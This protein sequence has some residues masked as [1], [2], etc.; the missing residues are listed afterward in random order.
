MTNQYNK[1]TTI[2]LD[3][4]NRMCNTGALQ[5]ASC[6]SL[7]NSIKK[8]KAASALDTTSSLDGKYDDYQRDYGI[9]LDDTKR[10]KSHSVDLSKLESF[11]LKTIGNKYLGYKD[12]K[13]ELFK[14]SDL[15]NEED[16]LQYTL[17]NAKSENAESENK[18]VVLDHFYIT[19]N[20]RGNGSGGGTINN[21]LT[22]GENDSVIVSK[23]HQLKSLWKFIKY[24]EQYYI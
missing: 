18:D 11:R 5:T 1:N 4:I 9:Y 7:K 17:I 24:N 13:L 23:K 22:L 10:F 8:M 2:L 12:G 20:G 16:T 15:L 14:E 21:Y 3:D 19:F 6:I